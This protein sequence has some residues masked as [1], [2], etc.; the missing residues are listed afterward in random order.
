MREKA[1]KRYVKS[2]DDYLRVIYMLK[3]S[4]RDAWGMPF[5]SIF[6]ILGKTWKRRGPT[7]CSKWI[8]CV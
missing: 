3:I 6:S 7:C 1:R 4:Y 2:K 8:F 5:L